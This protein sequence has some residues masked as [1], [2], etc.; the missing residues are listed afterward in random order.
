MRCTSVGAGMLLMLLLAA[1]AHAQQCKGVSFAPHVQVQGAT[2]DLNGLGLREA[3]FFKV[4]VY[5]A[6]LY[7]AM[8]AHDPAE[9]LRQSPPKQ[10]LLQFV[11]GVGVTDLRE[12]FAKGFDSAAG[13]QLPALRT[14]IASL[15]GMLRDVRS[16]ERMGFT[17]LRDHSV[18]FDLDGQVRGSIPGEDF[19]QALLRIWLGE[20][21]PNPELKSGLLGGAC[22]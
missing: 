11:R 13:A 22:P 9:L 2:L 20:H 16:G 21:P 6:A 19:G 15:Q 12:A 4:S 3:T 1:Q 7:V 5:V 10:L 17:W 14:R 18:Q 8:P